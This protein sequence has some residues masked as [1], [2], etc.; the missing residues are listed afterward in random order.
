L[1]LGTEPGRKRKKNPKK[2]FSTE[3]GR[4]DS[5][6]SKN[7]ATKGEVTRKGNRLGKVEGKDPHPESAKNTVGK[8]RREEL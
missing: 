8:N 5:H 2:T 6:Q 1:N 7:P 3:K 4:G